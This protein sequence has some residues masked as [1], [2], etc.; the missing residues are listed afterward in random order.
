MH[1]DSLSSMSGGGHSNLETSVLEVPP[2]VVELVTMIGAKL[3]L[4]F[5]VTRIV[6]ALNTT[7]SRGCN[8]VIPQEV[9]EQ[10]EPNPKKGPLLLHVA[11]RV[12]HIRDIPN[13]GG[14]YGVDVG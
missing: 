10:P 1:I 7:G 4:L 6:S 3:F 11:L 5:F 14:S 13:S 9:Q 8:L 12:V 2:N